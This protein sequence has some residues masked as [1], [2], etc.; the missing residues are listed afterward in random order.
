M[1]ARKYSV[2][3]QGTGKRGRVHIEYFHRDERFQVVGI[4]GRDP[5]RL[6]AAAPLAANPATFSD[7]AELLLH[8]ALR[9][10]RHDPRRNRWRR[11]ADRLRKAHGHVVQ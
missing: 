4:S 5:A 3:I 8:A 9:A 6:V 11:E 10:P 2:A 1:A 7:P